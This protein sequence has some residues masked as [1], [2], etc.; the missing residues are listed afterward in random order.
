MLKLLVGLGNPG[1]GYAR[2]RHNVGFRVASCFAAEHGIALDR[3]EFGGIFGRG[4][5]L[6]GEALPLEVAVLEPQTFM[7]RSGGAIAEAIRELS[8]AGPE[9]LLVVFD[10]VDLSFGRLRLRP[11]GGAGGHRGLA[12][13]IESLERESFPRLRFGV[14]RPERGYETRDHVLQ[15]FSLDEER[16]LPDLVA[17][18]AEA[19]AVTLTLGVD[20][21]MN[22]Y[23]ADPE[24]G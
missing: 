23:N 3:E 24:A 1:P 17:R 21:A 4:A 16:A 22:R 20:T 7:N 8:V 9:D 19:V 6:S 2:T 15:G 13:V 12:D 14:G 10:D 5:I 18:A 11:A